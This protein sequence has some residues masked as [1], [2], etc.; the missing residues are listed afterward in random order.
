MPPTTLPPLVAPLLRRSLVIATLAWALTALSAGAPS[1]VFEDDAYFY[2][3]IAWNLSHGLGASF[4]GQHV[5]SGFHLLWMTVLTPLAWLTWTLGFGKATF[6]G[7]ASAAALT[8]V[9]VTAL[10]G[11]HSTRERLFVLVL[12]LFCGLTME[13]VLLT[14]LLLPLAQAFL[15]TRRLGR[16]AIGALCVL[17]PLAR[18][19]YAWVA[20]A[21][22]VAAVLDAD[23]QAPFPWPPVVLGTVLGI[24]LYVGI[25]CALFDHWTSI[26]SVYKADLLS[27]NGVDWLVVENTRKYGN[28]MRYLMLAAM[29]TLVWR[30]PSAERRRATVLVGIALIPVLIH[31]GTNLIRDWYFLAPLVL[32]L[33]AAS[34]VRHTRSVHWPRLVVAQTVLVVAA[35]IGYLAVNAGDWQRARA[36]VR[37]ANRV[38]PA[39]ARVYQ[40]DGAGFSGWWLSAPVVNGDGLVNSWRYRERWL[41][42]DLGTYLQDTGATHVVIN[43]EDP[44]IEYHGLRL[45]PDMVTTVAD[46]GPMRNPHARLRLLRLN[47]ARV[48][49]AR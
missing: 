14:A 30:V 15:G 16:V 25:E 39:D 4:D 5:T 42:N 41:R 31:T 43:D 38:L 28:Q 19:D 29:A 34:H 32:M 17:V 8:L 9:A 37:A 10:Q 46:S 20:P 45:T 22:A 11:F 27:E 40:I 13:G 36:F 1:L 18:I 7:V 48:S 49:A 3:Q 26:S 6:A 44:P 23:D 24:G 35:S 33:G 47:D 2:L 12:S 21:L